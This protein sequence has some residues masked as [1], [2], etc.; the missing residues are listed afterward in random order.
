MLLGAKPPAVIAAAPPKAAQNGVG[1]ADPACKSANRVV[2][3]DRRALDAVAVEPSIRRR[4]SVDMFLY[5]L[6]LELYLQV[7]LQ[8]GFDEM[9]TLRE[10]EDDDM[11]Q[12]GMLPYHIQQLRQ[13][14]VENR[15]E[16]AL[17]ANPVAVF[18]RSHGLGVHAN[19]FVQSGFDEMDLLFELE[20]ADLN[21]LGVSRGHALKL[22]RHLRELQTQGEASGMRLARV[23]TRGAPQAPQAP[24]VV[25]A[26]PQWVAVE[27][28]MN[29]AITLECEEA[30]YLCEEADYFSSRLVGNQASPWNEVDFEVG[31]R[32]VQKIPSTGGTRDLR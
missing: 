1:R 16:E 20:D 8:N 10:I 23:A 29:D 17:A 2:A 13:S 19:S 22:R 14:L 30:D 11:R 4:C 18:L 27:Q 5:R 28:M 21:D 25:G 26:H 31:P 12:L 32:E 3:L 9:D 7:F 24:Q 15:A 6:G